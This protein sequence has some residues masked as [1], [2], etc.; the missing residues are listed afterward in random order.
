VKGK[1]AFGKTRHITIIR[2]KDLLIISKG[3]A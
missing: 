1:V 3:D 2:R